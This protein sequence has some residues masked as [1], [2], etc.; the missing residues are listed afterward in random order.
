ML[1]VDADGAVHRVCGAANQ[2]SDKRFQHNKESS[3]QANSPA[4][5]SGEQQILVRNS[6]HRSLKELI[7]T[8]H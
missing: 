4:A 7:I 8:E 3:P 1:K 5:L 2:I 6:C